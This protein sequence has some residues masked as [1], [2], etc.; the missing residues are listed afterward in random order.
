MSAGKHLEHG[1]MKQGAKQQT[2]TGLVGALDAVGYLADEGLATAAYLAMAMNRPLFCEGDAGVGKTALATALAAV[3]ET[4][5]IRLQCYEGIDV[6]HALYDWDYPRQLLQL[7]AGGS[8]QLYS[9][10]FLLRRPLLRDV[11]A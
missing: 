11:N 1:R 10:E 3:L 7:R 8:T 6:H 4:P 2:P 5:L 9:A